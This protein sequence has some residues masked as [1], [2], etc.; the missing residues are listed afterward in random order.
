[1]VSVKSAPR[2]EQYAMY[3]ASASHRWRTQ[4]EK[5]RATNGASSGRSERLL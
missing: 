5:K 4:H 2:R 3:G 1:L